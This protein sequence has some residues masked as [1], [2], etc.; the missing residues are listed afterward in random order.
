M[1]LPPPSTENPV[2]IGNSLTGP[3]KRFSEVVAVLRK[4]L[5][6]VLRLR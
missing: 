6:P 3:P 5:E 2:P 4:F 1:V